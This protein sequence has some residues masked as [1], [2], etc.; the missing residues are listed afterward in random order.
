[1]II[2]INALGCH[3]TSTTT[4]YHGGWVAL[5]SDALLS[6]C[7][8]LKVKSKTVLTDHQCQLRTSKDKFIF[9]QSKLY[10]IS[11]K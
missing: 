8:R 3:S 7:R 2:F 4:I 11:F 6:I 10:P 5:W 9:R 1:M